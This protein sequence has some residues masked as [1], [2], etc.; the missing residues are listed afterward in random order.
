MDKHLLTTKTSKPYASHANAVVVTAE[1]NAAQKSRK[2]LMRLLA[3][4]RNLLR[5]QPIQQHQFQQFRLQ[6]LCSVPSPQLQVV[7]QPLW[8]HL[9]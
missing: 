5:P 4:T 7:R 3:K 2:G 1:V 9:L 8:P 6:H